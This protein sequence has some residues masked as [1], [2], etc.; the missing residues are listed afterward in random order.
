MLK[1]LYFPQ[2]IY[3]LMLMRKKHMELG[4]PIFLKNRQQ[5]NCLNYSWETEEVCYLRILLLCWNVGKLPVSNW[6]SLGDFKDSPDVLPGLGVDV[7][8]FLDWLGHVLVDPE[9]NTALAHATGP[10]P[11]ILPGLS[12][13]FGGGDGVAGLWHSKRVTLK[14]AV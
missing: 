12:K 13:K 9:G 6:A 10:A 14:I 11:F 8:L 2:K 1:D 7:N 4:E 3:D 5:R